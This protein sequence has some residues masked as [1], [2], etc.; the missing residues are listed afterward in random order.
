MPKKS[1]G[2]CE[3]FLK[4][5]SFFTESLELVTEMKSFNDLKVEFPKSHCGYRSKCTKGPTEQC[6]ST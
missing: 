1:N 2:I 4:D 3:G 5:L 6:F